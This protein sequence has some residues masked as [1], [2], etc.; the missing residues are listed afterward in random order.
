MI[1]AV[2]GI[3][4]VFVCLSVLSSVSDVSGL[5]ISSLDHT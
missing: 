1:G 2:L 4:T 5:P 3:C